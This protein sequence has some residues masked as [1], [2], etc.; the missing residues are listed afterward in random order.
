M[1]AS[2]AVARM[3]FAAYHAASCNARC[4]YGTVAA[5]WH[6]RAGLSKKSDTKSRLGAA[7]GSTK[8]ALKH[9]GVYGNEYE[10]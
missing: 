5:C 7:L 10:L 9:L 2:S 6:V 1:D 3:Q 8:A 4:I